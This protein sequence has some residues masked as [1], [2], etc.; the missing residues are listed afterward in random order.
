MDTI[1]KGGF[2]FSKE[3]FEGK[4]LRDYTTKD[5]DFTLNVLPRLKILSG[6]I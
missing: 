2:K 4:R 3:S 6:K 5:N 1:L